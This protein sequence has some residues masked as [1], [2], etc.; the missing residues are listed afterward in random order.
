[1][2][3]YE[4][5]EGTIKLPLRSY[6][7][8]RTAV[9]SSFNRSQDELLLHTRKV[10]EAAKQAGFRKR[11]FS[12]ADWA[13]SHHGDV[14]YRITKR[15]SD[16]VFVPK[17]KDFP[18]KPTSKSIVLEFNEVT[19]AFDNHK[20]T[21]HYSV[22]ENNHACEEARRH[23]VVLSLFKNLQRVHHW[24]K[25]SGGE[26]VGNDEYNRDNRG[27]DGGANYITGSFGP[28]KRGRNF[29]GMYFT[30]GFGRSF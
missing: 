29:N 9:I 20:R 4:W 19:I 21:V 6:S 3:R 24:T 16:K 26:I 25:G 12:R 10:Y 14:A 1:M 27:F 28:D 2:S 13:R 23:P 11:G 7:E 15:G 30:K 8:I 22:S 5:E 17:R 18:H